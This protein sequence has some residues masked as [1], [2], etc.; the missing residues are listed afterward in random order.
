MLSVC[1]LVLIFNTASA[2]NALKGQE[3]FLQKCASCHAADMKSKLSGPALGGVTERWASRNDLYEWIRNSQRMI[4]EVKH[5]RAL[6][7]WAQWKPTVMNSFPELK[8]EDI[9]DMLLYI[10]NVAKNGCAEPPCQA[11]AAAAGAEGGAK[12]AEGGTSYLLWML[13]ITLIFGVALLG[14]YINSLSRLAQRQTGEEIEEEKSVLQILLNP[15]VV[16]LFIFA[17]VLLGGYTT[18]NTAI[19]L[20][21]QQGYAP[22]QPIK[23]SHALHAG[24]HGIDCQYCHDGAR[25][26]KHGLIPAMN[27][28]M[29]CHAA[30]NKGP[31]YGTAEILKIY[32]STGYNPNA[33]GV[34]Y[35]KE[36]DSLGY[37]MKQ[38]EDWLMSMADEAELK[39][40][41]DKVKQSVQEQLQAIK[42]FIGKTVEWVKIHNL[43]DHAYFNHAQ[44]VTVGKVECQTCHGKIQEMEVVKQYAPLSMGWCINC[45]RQTQVK[46]SENEYYAGKGANGEANYKH[47]EKYYKEIEAGK[48]SGV[49]VEDIGGLECQKC[50]Y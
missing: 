4:N 31:Q 29:N 34:V 48:R 18:V 16:K 50:H 25:R 39:S 28:C 2:Q 11:A 13:I 42:P 14:R 6:E 37:R 3:L 36:T 1:L 7:L 20:G 5:P 10:E 23:F 12:K 8:N 26:S 41:P 32:A 15:T 35:F 17:L 38:Y 40:N 19:G 47:F 22:E 21:R 49:T 33:N 27:T 46:F 44:H 24:K 43:P 45:H 9:D 30:V